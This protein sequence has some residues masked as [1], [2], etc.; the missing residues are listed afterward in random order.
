M[1]YGEKN[2]WRKY[3]PHELYHGG[4]IIRDNAFKITWK[5]HGLLSFK[6]L[7][8]LFPYIGRA[9]EKFL[10]AHRSCTQ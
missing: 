7:F 2:V 4:I 3:L 5:G 10:H 6:A 1:A 9:E 8:I